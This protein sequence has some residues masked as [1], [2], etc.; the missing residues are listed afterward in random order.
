MTRGQI[1]QLQDLSKCYMPL[2][3]RF[4]Y[5][6][7]WQTDRSYRLDKQ[8]KAILRRLTHQYRNQIAAMKRNQR[9]NG[10]Q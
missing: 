7:L 5:G 8:D 6:W 3:D 10:I 2:D 1:A 9:T 4:T